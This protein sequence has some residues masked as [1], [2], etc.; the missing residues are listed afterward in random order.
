MD[1]PQDIAP[2]ARVLLARVAAELGRRDPGLDASA[3]KA[4][5]GGRWPGNARQLSNVLERALVLRPSGDLQP[6]SADDLSG[7]AAESNRSVRD[8]LDGAASDATSSGALGEKVAALE[9]AEIE[10]ALRRARGV[11]SRAASALGLSRPT[12]D[13][14]LAEL[15]I[16]LWKP[17][18]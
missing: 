10:A 9:R 1:R 16:D 17:A 15:G 18:E 13:K 11:K 12:L 5:A 4:L 2:L 7:A 14:K 3:E 6:L 8:R